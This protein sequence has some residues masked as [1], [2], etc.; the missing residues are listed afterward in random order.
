MTQITPKYK[1]LECKHIV[2]NPSNFNKE[3]VIKAK[4]IYSKW[5]EQVNREYSP[6]TDEQRNE[7]K[8]KYPKIY[9]NGQ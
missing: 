2:E 4:E 1:I 6:I 7:L 5:V 8:K 3:A 9:K